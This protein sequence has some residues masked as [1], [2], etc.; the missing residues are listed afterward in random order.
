MF[1]LSKL[2]IIRTIGVGTFG[3]VY[4]TEY[5]SKY[6]ALKAVSTSTLLK[7][8]Q[9]DHLNEERKTLYELFF[10][11]YFVK[12]IFSFKTSRSY[13]LVLEYVGGGELF[14]WLRK[15]GPFKLKD[16]RFYA[17]EITLALEYLF[18]KNLLYRDLKP[19]NILLTEKG[20]IK[21]VDLGFAKKLNTLTF[22]LCGTP[23]YMAP[24][25]LKSEGYGQSSDLWSLGILIYEML[26][27]MPP[28]YSKTPYL[29]YQKILT[30][31]PNYS[32]MDLIAV[33]LTEQLLEKDPKK[34]LSDIDKIK[35]HPFFG[36]I[37]DVIDTIEPPIIPKL[38]CA[39]DSQYFIE[40]SEEK[41]DDTIEEK[42][43]V[44]LYYSFE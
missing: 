38:S 26:K 33:D 7:L 18:S 31:T 32:D 5:N 6:Y 2:K 37:F 39:G 25:K 3:R 8:K 29:I 9:K 42:N 14:Y 44:K 23:E 12:L 16:A 24:E 10:C 21:L 36:K 1:E 43:R 41:G 13:F 28:F 11:K 20:H 4:L 19:E 27:G 35:K 40:Y 30:E 34:R 22:T 15:R 17:A